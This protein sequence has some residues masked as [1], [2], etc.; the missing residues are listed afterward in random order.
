MFEKTKP[1]EAKSAEVVTIV[2]V[3]HQAENNFRFLSEPWSIALRI[4]SSRSWR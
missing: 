1:I 2:A 4:L 3:K